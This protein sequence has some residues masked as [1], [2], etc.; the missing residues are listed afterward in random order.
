MGIYRNVNDNSIYDNL[1]LVERNVV[2]LDLDEQFEYERIWVFLAKPPQVCKFNNQVNG[3]KGVGGCIL[4]SV[5]VALE[6]R[7]HSY[8]SG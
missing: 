1:S 6:A 7:M 2:G 8:L 4:A 5:I 3:A